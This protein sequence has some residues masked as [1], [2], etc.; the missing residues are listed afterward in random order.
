MPD[1]EET[2][3]SSRY[4]VPGIGRLCTAGRGQPG[5]DRLPTLWI[6]AA[7]PSDVRPD[8]AKTVCPM[9]EMVLLNLWMV[10]QAHQD[11][12]LVY[13]WFGVVQNPL[14]MRIL[15]ALGDDGLIV[16]DP[17]ALAKIVNL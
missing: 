4:S 6:V 5:F 17:S 13:A 15:L 14:T 1:H 3:H 9:A 10:R 2:I 16:D 8:S 12:R 11:G 7:E